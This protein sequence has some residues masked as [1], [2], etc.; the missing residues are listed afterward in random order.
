[1]R[2]R[3]KIGLVVVVLG[4]VFLWGRCSR[5]TSPQTPKLPSVLPPNDAE[6]IRVNP[7]TRQITI[8]TPTGTRT[9]TLP[10]TTSTIDVLRN[11]Q[12]RVT[13]PQFGFEH[14]LFVGYTLSDAGRFT[15]GMDGCYWKRLDLGL[16]VADQFGGHSPIALAKLTYNVK[17]SLQLGLTYGSNQFIGAGLYL[18]VF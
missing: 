14:H 13:A 6:Q 10:D 11:G 5:R 4:S 16:G 15:V 17:G 9:V 2:L 8:T 3:T 1:V 7:A 12:V 18:R